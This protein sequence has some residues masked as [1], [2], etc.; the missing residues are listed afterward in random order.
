MVQQCQLFF[1][2][3]LSLTALLI[4][5][6]GVQIAENHEVGVL[7]P[8]VC[9]LGLQCVEERL[10]V[11]IVSQGTTTVRMVRDHEEVYA[12]TQAPDTAREARSKRGRHLE[13][14][15]TLDMRQLHTRRVR[16]QPDEL[17]PRTTACRVL[18]P[19]PA[20]PAALSRGGEGAG[21]VYPSEQ[22]PELRRVRD[23]LDGQ[24]IR[25]YRQ[26]DLADAILMGVR[27][28][29]VPDVPGRDAKQRIGRRLGEDRLRHRFGAPLQQGRA[30][31]SQS[32]DAHGSDRA[33]RRERPGGRPLL[34]VPDVQAGVARSN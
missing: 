33:R 22:T 4:V 12:A 11:A 30:K 14:R 10:P 20:N 23:L 18:D 2:R 8:A 28:A 1:S 29:E 3:E 16:D 13:A 31:D 26:K 25:I 27:T 19:V 32:H 21:C 5:A 17:I 9:Q 15:Q 6:H 7:R 24:E 34:G